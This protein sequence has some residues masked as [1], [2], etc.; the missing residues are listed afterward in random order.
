MRPLI[1]VLLLAACTPSK[2]GSSPAVPDDTAPVDSGDAVDTDADTDADTGTDT[3]TDTDTAPPECPDGTE[4]IG[5]DCVDI[6]ECLED[7]GGCGDPTHWVCENQE[8]APP[9]CTFDPTADIASLNAGVGSLHYGGGLS[10]RMVVWGETAFPIAWD[11]TEAVV[12]AAARVGEGRILHLG[13]EGQLRGG[14]DSGGAGILV[15]NALAWMSPD[16]SP[17]I[18]ISPG[19]DATRAWLEAAG[20]TVLTAG[21]G[22]L[23]AIDV[24]VTSTSD[25]HAPEEDI[26]IREWVAAGGGVIAGGHA[27]WWAYSTGS[28]DVFHDHPG[29]QWLGVAGITLSGS[30]AGTEQVEVPTSTLPLLHAGVA[31]DA[32]A[33][34]VD[35]RSLLDDEHAVRAAGAAGFAASVLPVDS[36]WFIDARSILEATAPVV[37]TAASPVSPDEQPIEALVVRIASALAQRLPAEDIDRHPAAADFPGEPPAGTMQEP[38]ETTVLASYAGRDR[39][40]LYSGAGADVWRSTG[41][42]IPAGVPITVTLPETAVDTG[43]RLRVGAHSDRLWGKSSWERMPEITRAWPVESAETTVASAFGGPLYVQIPEGVELGE[44]TVQID[45]AVPMARFVAGVHA[46]TDWPDLTAA[47]APWGELETDGLI[48]T[49]PTADLRAVSSPAAL[50]TFWQAVMDAQAE[51]ASIPTER[52]RPERI[53]VDRQISAGWMHSGYPIMAHLAS[54]PDLTDLAHLQTSGDWGAFHE[55]GHNHQWRDWLLPGTTETTCNLWSV[56]TMETVVGIDR[57][58][59]HS[60]LTDANRTSRIDAYVA[61]GLD[62]NADWSV[63]TALETWLQ[64]QEEFGWAPI[65]TAQEAYLADAPGDDPGTD[66]GRIDRWAVRV[67]EST[68]RDLSDFLDA[69]GVPLTTSARAQMAAYPEWTDHPMP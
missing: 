67:S 47:D 65:I 8:A 30:T 37:P 49:V 55:L 52:V 12:A 29:N 43:I 27:W 25:D 32:A 22:S 34:H 48:L 38:I 45:R 61:G 42:W 40:Y 69:W 46:D 1:G 63:W 5:D 15:Q 26:A 10:S 3:D 39:R 59:G 24:W 41:A 57:S 60:A 11:D 16:A 53:V 17:T 23:S 66:Q 18:G 13:H 14:L 51:L 64:L 9:V 58:D 2:T 21:P 31:L 50:A 4:A 20:Y 56:Y 33:D 7:N 28:D 54:G 68:G 35:G 6:D 44:I 36:P 19:L 62:F